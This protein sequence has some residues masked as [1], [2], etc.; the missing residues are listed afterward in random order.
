M[1]DRPLSALQ[2]APVD[3]LHHLGKQLAIRAPDIATL[4]FGRWTASDRVGAVGYE[5][6]SGVT[7]A[8]MLRTKIWVSG[9]SAIGS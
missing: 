7:N 8:A 4:R 1:C 5:W 3:L 6:V 9:T 2:R